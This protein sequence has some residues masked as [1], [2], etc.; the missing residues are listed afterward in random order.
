LLDEEQTK[1]FIRYLEEIKKWN[2]K[3]NLTSLNNDKDIIEQLFINSLFFALPISLNKDLK[4]LDLG[5]GA[6]FP[7]L[8]IK[9]LFPATPVTLLEASK[10]KTAFLKHMIRALNM[11]GVECISKRSEELAREKERIAYYDII[12]TRGTGS[13]KRIIKTSL[14]LLKEGG[15]FISQKGLESRDETD[16]EAPRVKLFKKKFFKERGFILLIFKKCFT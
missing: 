4:I 13:I 6:G 9:I 8:P 7:G 10:R 14:P 3:I 5:S 16:E 1:K 11:K 2:E 15:L 12:L